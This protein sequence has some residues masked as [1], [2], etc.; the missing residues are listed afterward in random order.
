M[1]W[2][3]LE[4]HYEPKSSLR[5]MLRVL[6]P[7]GYGI[8]AVPSGD[9]VG[10]SLFG[11]NWGPLEAPRHLYHFTE[12]T[13]SRMC[14]DAGFEIVRFFYDFTFYGLFLDQEIFESLENIAASNGFTLRFPRVP[15]FSSLFRIPVLPFNKV[16]G[17]I[18]RGGNLIIHVRKPRSDN[19]D[20]KS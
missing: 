1:S 7:G 11:A 8:V 16:L 20:Q 18:W 12:R 14:R 13:L 4:H 6:R 15:L 10:L 5:E 2:H 3:S 9:N 17:R 19:P